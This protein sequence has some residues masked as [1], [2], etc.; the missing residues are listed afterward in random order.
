MDL[1]VLQIARA[2]GAALPQAELHQPHLNAAMAQFSI[3]TPAR[4]AAFLANVS[5]ETARLKS[6][7]EDLFY[8][9]PVRL[10]K[11]YPRAFLSPTAAIPFV[12]NSKALGDKLYQGFFGRGTLMLTWLRNYKAAS[13]ALGYDYVSDPDLV[14][15][16]KHAALTAAWFFSTNG[17]NTAADALNIGDVRL[18]IN[19]PARLHLAEVTELFNE[20]MG[21]LEVTA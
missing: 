7:Q 8:R 4:I 21:W 6:M 11:I 12:K 14:V 1:T 17:C 15:Q 16:P 3:T 10:A 9:D 5:I 2:T 19:G 20:T 18:R 13:A